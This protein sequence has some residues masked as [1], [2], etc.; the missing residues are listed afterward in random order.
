MPVAFVGANSVLNSTSGSSTALPLPTATAAGN[1][2]Y[3]FVASIGNSPTPTAPSGWTLVNS[4]SPGTTLTSYLYRKVAVSGDNTATATWSWSSAGRNIGLSLAYS[5]VDATVATTS[6]AAWTNNLASAPITAPS[7]A[8]SA[9]DWLATVGVARESPGTA[10]TKVWSNTTGTDAA[11]LAVVTT[12]IA[13]DVKVPATW[14]DSAG[15][16]AAGSTARTVQI[17]PDMQQSHVW[18][19]LLPV[20]AGEAAGG[21]P[22]THMGMPLR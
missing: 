1:M 16:V 14:W 20:P 8:A 2:I 10:T 7:L 4:F 12:G 11:R 19:I 17:T 3:A 9:G 13:T 21:N 22:W 5:G 18:S 15:P 6:S